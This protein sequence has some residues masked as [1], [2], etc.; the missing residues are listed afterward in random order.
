MKIMRIMKRI[1]L[2]LSV[3]T[4]SAPLFGCAV[5]G[6][7]AVN[8]KSP[9]PVKR[10][11]LDKLVIVLMPG[12]DTP[13]VAYTRNLFDDALSKALMGLPVEEYHATN[14]SAMIEAM[15]TGHAH[16]GSFGPFAYVH[17]VERSGAECFAV[18]SV[19]GTHG[20]TSLII[21]HADSGINSLD[22]LKGCNFGFVDPESTSG[23]IVPSNEILIH[24][25]ESMP[26]LT[27][28]DL[29]VN[30]RFFESVMFTGT[31][32][33][34]AQG[35]YRKDV[36]AAAV[37]SSTLASQVRSGEIEEDKIRIIHE[38]PRI[39]SSPLAIQKDLP[40][41]LKDLVIKFFLDWTDEEFWSIRSSTPGM[42]YW[43]VYDNEYD[44]VRELRD[45]F[46]LSD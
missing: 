28:E 45:K 13:E 10:W 36:D 18:S 1:A 15:R 24:Y 9:D 23:N 22:G 21:T 19:D 39:P 20:Y 29:H 11:G 3:I 35:V 5:S 42:K 4:L 31:H 40:E 43:P 46:D 12:E 26:D 7:S 32:A 14:Y 16:V 37:S 38:S 2:L 25:A 34:S 44:Y 27:F 33:N 6:G 41:E 8:P 30:G 17:A